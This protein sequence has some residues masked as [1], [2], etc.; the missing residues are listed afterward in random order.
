MT[1]HQK[2][3]IRRMLNFKFFNY[4]VEDWIGILLLIIL[5]LVVLYQVVMRVLSSTPPLWTE[6]I[7][8]YLLIILTFM[9]ASIAVRNGS[10]ISLDFILQ[11]IPKNVSKVILIVARIIEIIFYTICT[12]LSIQMSKFSTG[13]FLVSIHISRMLIYGLLALGF[14]MM[15]F[16]AALRMYDLVRGIDNL[17]GV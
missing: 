3:K 11:G 10:N 1:E 17:E 6:E 13:R 16:R 7:A 2:G 14:A 8:R 12:V 9:G 5:V 4:Y 15:T